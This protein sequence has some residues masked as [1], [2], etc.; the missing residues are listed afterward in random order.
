M[1]PRD[2]R[3]YCI[4]ILTSGR[5]IEVT[6]A[7]LDF[8]DYQRVRTVNATVER[9]F[10]IIG[11]AVN[12]LLRLDASLA[13]RFP[14]GPA[15]IAFRNHLVHRYHNVSDETVWEIV[16]KSLPEVIEAARVLLVELESRRS[17]E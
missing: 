3:A 14:S 8:E 13:D 1:P 15:I 4:D 9:E 10:I 16:K 17:S 11:E 5:S 6:V 2:L 7:G 12:Q